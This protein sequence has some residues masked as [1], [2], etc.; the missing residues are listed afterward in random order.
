MPRLSQAGAVQF[1]DL[2]SYDEACL[3]R[4]CF[5]TTNMTTSKTVTQTQAKPNCSWK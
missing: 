5:R 4:Q 1:I 2:K 3:L